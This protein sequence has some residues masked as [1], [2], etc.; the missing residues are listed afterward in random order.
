[1]GASAEFLTTSQAAEFLGVS[2][3]TIVRWA[4][5]GRI[6]F[7][8]GPNN[9]RLFRREDLEAV[10]VRLEEEPPEPDE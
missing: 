5:H 9:E 4:A 2:P 3:S 8:V 10:V 1:V 6:P 7:H